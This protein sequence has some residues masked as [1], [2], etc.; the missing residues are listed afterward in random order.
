MK[1][2]F[3][4]TAGSNELVN[5][6]IIKLVRINIDY[7]REDLEIKLK[8]S[9]PY[10]LDKIKNSNQKLYEIVQEHIIEDLKVNKQ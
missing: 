2:R 9:D 8:N 4:E 3:N 10:L 7:Q 1:N 5:S 6:L